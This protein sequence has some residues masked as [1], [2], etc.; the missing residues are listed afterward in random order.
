MSA[1]NLSD[2]EALVRVKFCGDSQYV[3]PLWGLYFQENNLSEPIARGLAEMTVQRSGN[4]DSHQLLRIVEVEQQHP[5]APLADQPSL[6]STYTRSTIIDLGQR[7][8]EVENRKP[9]VVDR[10]VPSL[11]IEVRQPEFVPPALPPVL[12]P[13]TSIKPPVP[14]YSPDAPGLA[15]SLLDDEP[16]EPPTADHG[17]SVA[18][19]NE[20][21]RPPQPTPKPSAPPEN[22]SAPKPPV[23]RAAGRPPKPVANP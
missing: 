17:S 14:I 19:P 6:E 3:G 8:Q 2:S 4:N 1:E 21:A 11:P 7:R 18:A 9:A 22:P 16:T 13:V 5:F 20:L 15:A 23:R 10:G 12:D